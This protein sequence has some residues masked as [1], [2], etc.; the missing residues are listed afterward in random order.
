MK[1]IKR[2]IVIVGSGA[3]GATVAKELAGKGKKVIVLEKGSFTNKIGNLGYALLYYDKLALSKS[4]E[5]YIIY[6][7]IT[8]GGTTLCSCGNGVRALEN[9][10]KS[11]GIDLEKEF[12]ETEKELN[13][14]PLSDNLM[15]GATKRIMESA[16]ELGYEMR[17]M[18]KFIDEKCISCGNCIYGCL[19][20]AKWSSRK[21]LKEAEEKGVEVLYGVDVRKVL[22][23]G[24]EAVG[25]K[26]VSR[27]RHIVVDANIVVV[28]AGGIGTPVLLQ[29]SGI[30]SGNRLFVIYSKVS[31]DR[32]KRTRWAVNVV[33]RRVS[34]C[35]KCRFH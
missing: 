19:Q 17:P 22:V 12:E 15:G 28:A 18:P 23:S 9:K 32:T 11:M 2:D 29:N 25:V 3:G 33:A 34:S 26:G 30:N 14:V 10:L 31:K 35:P 7:N 1:R 13:I 4:I 21:Y 24:K 20:D 27:G 8:S 16:C 6:R 5:G